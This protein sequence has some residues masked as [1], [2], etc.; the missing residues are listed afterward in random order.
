VLDLTNSKHLPLALQ[1]LP[2]GEIWNIGP[3]RAE[4]LQRNSITNAFIGY[5][6]YD[7]AG[8]LIDRV[9]A[10]RLAFGFTQE[11]MS[12]LL[13]VDESSLAS[14][15]RREHKPVRQSQDILREFLAAPRHYIYTANG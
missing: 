8:D 1:G 4:L 9:R 10:V 12:K 13:K 15:E 5:C 11:Q 2:M 6:P 3:A 14:W 7:T